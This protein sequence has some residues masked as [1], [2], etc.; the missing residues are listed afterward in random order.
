MG[1][2]QNKNVTYFEIQYQEPLQKDKKK[3]LIR[4]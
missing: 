1:Q 4:N 2:Y 3:K